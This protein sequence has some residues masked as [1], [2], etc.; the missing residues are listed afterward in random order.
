[1]AHIY[2]AF[3]L[4]RDIFVLKIAFINTNGKIHSFK[5]SEKLEIKFYLSGIV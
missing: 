5:I 3:L 2:S 1:M 4:V